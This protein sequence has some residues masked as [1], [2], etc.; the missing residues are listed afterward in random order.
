MSSEVVTDFRDKLS[1]DRSREI[2]KTQHKLSTA[3]ETY[4]S[5]QSVV[6][7]ARADYEEITSKLVLLRNE[8]RNL[9]DKV[10]ELQHTDAAI[11]GIPLAA[12]LARIQQLQ[13]Q[14]SALHDVIKTQEAAETTAS[15]ILNK[16]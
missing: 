5:L 13:Q 11:L 3:T 10:D 1:R 6:L 16:A 2:A 8:E 4:S 14:L 7:K 9:T 15:K 12:K